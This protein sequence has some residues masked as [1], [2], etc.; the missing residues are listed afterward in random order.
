[1][2]KELKSY[3]KQDKV[4]STYF[5]NVQYNIES[6]KMESLKEDI[7]AKTLERFSI[8]I[9]GNLTGYEDRIREHFTQQIDSF[10]KDS[11]KKEL[12]WEN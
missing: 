10:S 5:P 4:L 3:A 9:Q 12:S 1:M 2:L 7:L 11:K 6:L 8:V